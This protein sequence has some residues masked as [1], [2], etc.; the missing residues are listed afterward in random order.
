MSNE[1]DIRLK[2][3]ELNKTASKFV[4]Y[5]KIKIIKFIYK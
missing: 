5:K 2:L 4:F 3:M 1:K